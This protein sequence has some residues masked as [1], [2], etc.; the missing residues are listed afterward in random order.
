MHGVLAELRATAATRPLWIWGAGNQGRGICSVLQGHGVPLAGFLDQAADRLAGRVMGLPVA[1]P[2]RVLNALDGVASS[3]R[4]FVV[5]ASWFFEAEIAQRLRAAGLGEHDDFIGYSRLKPVDYSVDIVGVCNL[6][7][8]ACP[9]ASR[10]PSDGKL[11]M[12]S[13][14]T[15]RLVLDKILA[16]SPFVGNLQLYQWGEPVLHPQLP[17]IVEHAR[18]RGVLCAISS[19]LNADVDYA[20]ILSARPEWLRISTSGWGEG[21]EMTHA[22]GRWPRFLEHL[23]EVATLRRTLHPEMKIEVY[24]HLYKHSVGDSLA[25]FQALCDELGLELHPIPAYLISLDDVLGYCEGRP[26]PEPARQAAEQLLVSLEDGLAAAYRERHRGCDVLRCVNINWDTSVSQCMLY[27]DSVGNTVAPSY[28][29]I[30]LERIQALRH[31]ADLC[32]RCT[33]YGLH[34]Y[35]ASYA[36]MEPV[37]EAASA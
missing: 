26:L 35:C 13:L 15:F 1:E 4:P 20:R 17:E 31:A 28:L 22:R 27:Y 8:L 9:R 18:S 36:R 11:G 34:Q 24:Y 6:K 7:C 21:Y 3:Q 30:P 12:M 37:S 19:N 16:E 25:R 32:R 23:R 5:I 10:A 14:E 33:R 29:E 2:S